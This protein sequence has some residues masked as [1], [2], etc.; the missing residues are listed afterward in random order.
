MENMSNMKCFVITV[1]NIQESFRF[2]NRIMS[3]K[4]IKKWI[5]YARPMLVNPKG[6]S[7]HEFIL[8]LANT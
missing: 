2:L 6:L 5:S 7:P 8:L 4:L 1:K 3:D